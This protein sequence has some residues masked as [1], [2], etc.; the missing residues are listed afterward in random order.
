[1]IDSVGFRSSLPVVEIW[2]GLE[3]VRFAGLVVAVSETGDSAITT[4]LVYLFQSQANLSSGRLCHC[5][6]PRIRIYGT[7]RKLGYLIL[8]S[9]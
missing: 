7:F 8:G 9:L 4:V 3:G 1:M 6:D 5:Q 2:G